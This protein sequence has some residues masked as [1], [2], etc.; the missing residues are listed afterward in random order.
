MTPTERRVVDRLK[1]RRVERF[2]ELAKALDVSPKTVQRA[3]AQVEHLTSVNRNAAYVAL[4]EAARFD[5]RGLWRFEKTC[6]SRH[7]NLPQT[8]VALV[9][10]APLGHTLVELQE[11]LGTRMH[12]HVSRLIRAGKLTRFSLGRHAVYLASDRR[13]QAEQWAARQEEIARGRA[14]GVAD[15]RRLDVPPGLQPV[16]VIRVLVRLLEA[17]AASV[18]SVARWLQ[19]RDVE[20]SARQIRQILDFYG[21]KKTT[22]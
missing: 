6:F 1:R 13:R 2:A 16:T 8:I 20:V 5:E 7:G 14:V 11:L 9:Q 21:L 18:A 10:G 19:V 4:A 17:P 15:R 3:L 12:N 22:R